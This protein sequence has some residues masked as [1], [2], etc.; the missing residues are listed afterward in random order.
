MTTGDIIAVR[1]I[2]LVVVAFLFVLAGVAS[3]AVR[4]PVYAVSSFAVALLAAL[5]AR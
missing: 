1:R 5:G 3:L 2:M 4:N